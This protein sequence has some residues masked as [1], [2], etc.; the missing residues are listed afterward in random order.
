[1]S[2]S[3]FETQIS[4]FFLFIFQLSRFHGISEVG[5]SQTFKTFGFLFISDPEGDS[6][7]FGCGDDRRG[8][9]GVTIQ[10]FQVPLRVPVKTFSAHLHTVRYLLGLH[11]YHTNR[12]VKSRISISSLDCE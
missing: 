9:L 12:D 6:K 5:I 7:L 10:G 3:T 11:Q 2:I 8:F 1:M 4:R